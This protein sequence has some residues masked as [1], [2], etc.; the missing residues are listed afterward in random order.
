MCA[1]M[2]AKLKLGIYSGA[3]IPIPWDDYLVAYSAGLAQRER[4]KADPD[5]APLAQG[6]SMA[7]PDRKREIYERMKDKQRASGK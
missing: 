6:G 3:D 2:L 1:T 4:D 5:K 7:S